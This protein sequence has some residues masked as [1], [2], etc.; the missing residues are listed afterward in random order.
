M[1]TPNG[2]ILINSS[3]SIISTTLLY[4]INRPVYI[5]IYI[6]VCYRYGADERIKTIQY[7]TMTWQKCPKIPD[8]E[9]SLHAVLEQAAQCSKDNNK[10]GNYHPLNKR[11]APMAVNTTYTSATT[12]NASPKLPSHVLLGEIRGASITCP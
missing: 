2:Y 10:C 9:A 4:S 7:T 12:R 1:K 5:S 6:T 11:K 8:I 3:A